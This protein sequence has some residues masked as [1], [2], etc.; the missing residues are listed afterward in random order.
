MKNQLHNKLKAM[1]AVVVT[2]TATLAMV[3]GMFHYA[4]FIGA[5]FV[6]IALAMGIV[7]LYKRFL[8]IFND[9]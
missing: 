7:F 2:L 6:T 3:Y 9:E 8:D 5:L 1:L 4:N